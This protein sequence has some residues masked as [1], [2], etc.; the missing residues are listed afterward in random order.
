MLSKIF[1]DCFLIC[2]GFSIVFE[3]F[4]GFLGNRRSQEKLEK[5]SSGGVRSF[6][7]SIRRTSRKSSF[8]S[9]PFS[10]HVNPMLWIVD[11]PVCSRN[12]SH[13]EDLDLKPPNQV[14][15]SRNLNPRPKKCRFLSRTS[16]KKSFR[17]S[18]SCVNYRHPAPRRGEP[19]VCSARPDSVSAGSAGSAGSGGELPE[20]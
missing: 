9:N 17:A 4:V 2:S 7:K 8:R 13:E 12:P 15:F 16:K 3:F 20:A 5:K 18:P 19:R 6:R 10:T 14:P 11:P 1:S